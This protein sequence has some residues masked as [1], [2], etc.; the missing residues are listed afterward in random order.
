[1]LGEY[2]DEPG[3][4]RDLLDLHRLDLAAISCVE[5]WLHS[6]ETDAEVERSARVIDFISHFPGSLL[7]LCPASGRDR[8]NLSERQQNAIKCINRVARRAAGEGIACVVHPNAPL[9]SVFRIS[10]DYEVLVHGLDASCVGLIADIGNIAAGGIDPLDIIRIYRP[11][12]RH[13][14]FKYRLISGVLAEMGA[15]DIDFVSIASELDQTAYEGWVIIEDIT[16][17]SADLTGKFGVGGT[18]FADAVTITLLDEDCKVSMIR[19]DS[20]TVTSRNS[21]RNALLAGSI[22]AD[23]ADLTYV[24]AKLVKVQSGRIGDGC[25]IDRLECGP[26]VEVSSAAEVGEIVRYNGSLG[27]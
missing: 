14:H 15:G 19:A 9:G 27:G 11:L 4:F 17:G 22:E 2:G 18:L 5:N 12:I 6:E 8:A 3:K 20:V 21:G 13:V 1:M 26:D 16:V 23:S 24:W 7:Q 10:E 25:R